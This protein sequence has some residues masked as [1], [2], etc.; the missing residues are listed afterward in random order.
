M[1]SSSRVTKSAVRLNCEALEDRLTPTAAYALIPTSNSLIE[2]DTANPAIVNPPIA[3]TGLAGGENLVGI[4]VRPQNGFLYGLA[5][6]SANGG[7]V[8][9]YAI[10]GRTGV[11]TSL[12]GAAV[13][14]SD[15]AGAAVPITGAN[16][17]FDFNPSAD[18]IRVVTDTGMNFRINPNN[19]ALVDGDVNTG[20]TQPDG[21]QSGGT[22]ASAAA[23]T[24]SSPN[25][26]ATPAPTTTLY[27]LDATSISLYIQ[28]NPNGGT[29][30]L[31]APIT[32]NGQPLDFTA[33]N[34]FD[35]PSSVTVAQDNAAA[36]GAAFASLTT[37]ATGTHLYSIELSTGVATDL[38]AI[39][40]G[41][42][43]YNGLALLSQQPGTGT[44]GTPLIGVVPNGI[45]GLPNLARFN[46]TAATA[47]GSTLFPLNGVTSGETI[48]GI[49]FR[50]QTGQLIG[51]GINTA[52]QN[53]TTPPTATLYLIDPQTGTNGNPTVTVLTPVTFAAGTQLPAPTNGGNYGFDFNPTVD[54]IR[55]VTSTG[56]N[57]R[58]DPNNGTVTPDTAISG[59]TTTLDDV[60]YT[61]SF[62]QTLGT[63]NPTTLYGL[64]SASDSL[65]RFNSPNGGTT[66]LVGAITVNGTA[67][68]FT[69]VNGFDIPAGVNVATSNAAVTSG[70]GFA[71][72]TV[73]G[74]SSLYRIDL[75]TGA[76]TNL[77]TIGN[78]NNI[79]GALAA[80]DTPAGTITFGAATYTAAEGVGNAAV[81]LTRTGGTS[82]SVT[83]TVAVTG[84]TATAGSDFTAGPYMVT[85]ADGATTATLNIPIT[86]DATV[87]SSETIL[88]ALSAPTNTAV[89]GAQAATTL[90]ITDNDTAPPVT[91]PAPG[92]QGYVDRLFRAIL[93]RPVDPSGQQTYNDQLA[94]GVPRAT[95]VSE[96]LNSLEGRLQSINGLY[97]L[98]LGREVDQAAAINFINNNVPLFQVTTTI[99]GSQEYFN[100]NGGTN[101][102]F[103]TA[104]FRDLLGRPIDASGRDTFTT[105]LQ[106]ATSRGQVAANI[107]TSTEGAG[108][109][110]NLLFNRF[111]RRNADDGAITSFVPFFQQTRSIENVIIAIGSS[112]EFFQQTT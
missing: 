82:G 98:Y 16:F 51:L 18:R 25:S 93:N 27:V 110:V 97:R 23:Y 77:G 24:N 106:S 28:S 2:F 68:D 112:D 92:A 90:T 29:E 67:I 71:A 9:L 6:T 19:G 54:R 22:M 103:L 47:N 49:D 12:S 46:S 34:G 58:L 13:Q 45:F 35:I 55:L 20:G 38:G 10:S 76:A 26:T 66:V 50:P 78:G 14:F 39:G 75:T 57:F 69:A 80:A 31:V 48:V 62:G 73:G 96:I 91:P 79:F 95:V 104:V 17:G 7:S 60:A 61:N 109:V 37:T 85:F 52:N 63:M 111:L 43:P 41:T 3:V 44:A 74:A 108:R 81:T 64:D 42:V 86:D 21:M 15:A 105:A 89:I 56:Q 1:R 4:D 36:T 30:T 65:Y 32:L 59:G 94:N 88:L 53:T 100:R 102:G 11:A 5:Y 8:E 99:I 70:F 72:L 33:V 40:M 84:G 101:D 87:E 83:V 107:L